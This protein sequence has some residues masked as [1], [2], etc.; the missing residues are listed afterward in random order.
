MRSLCIAV[1]AISLYYVSAF[2]L[3][4]YP[5]YLLKSSKTLENEIR[6]APSDDI[7]ELAIRKPRVEIEYCLGCKWM[8]RSAYYAQELLTTFD[9]SIGEVALIPSSTTGNIYSTH[10][11]HRHS[12]SKHCHRHFHS[13][14]KYSSCMGSTQR[15]HQGI[16]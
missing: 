9:S 11:Y 7:T 4:V 1:F 6:L 3:L 2:R 5:S 13:A 12:S 16:S 15:E 14:S 10:R 8:L